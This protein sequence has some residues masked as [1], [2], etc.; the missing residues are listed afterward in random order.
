MTGLENIEQHNGF[1]ISIS[2]LSIVFIS[3]LL[4]SIYIALLPRV[5]ELVHRFL[6]EDDH[7]DAVSAKAEAEKPPQ[8]ESLK[9]AAAAAVAIHHAREGGR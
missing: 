4:I 7:P 1:Q 9:Q 8:Q 3:L 5:L 2:G 6:P